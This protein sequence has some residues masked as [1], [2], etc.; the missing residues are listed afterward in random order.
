MSV[1]HPARWSPQILDAVGPVI[2]K[3]GLPVHD[4]FAGTGERLGALCD[5][6]G[7]AFTGTELEPEF[8]LDPRVQWGD[9]TDTSTYPD[10]VHLIVTSPAY[11]NGMCDHFE[12]RDTSR[13]H[14]YRHSLDR[15]LHVNNMGRYSTRGGSAVKEAMHFGIAERC[16]RYWPNCAVVNVK[17]FVAKGKVYP[18]VATWRGLLSEAGFTVMRELEVRAP[19]QRHGANGRL[20]VAHEVI[21]LAKRL[22]ESDPQPQLKV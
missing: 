10:D 13:R 3:V 7:L 4:P 20:R 14:T 22:D 1:K 16:V 9:S 12:A 8:I 5:R 19:G 15:P 18:V 21:L 2:E 17:D 6:L 11:P